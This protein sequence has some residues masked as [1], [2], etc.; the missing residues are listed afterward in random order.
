M[1]V[2]NKGRESHRRQDVFLQFQQNRR[3]RSLPFLK[4]VPVQSCTMPEILFRDGYRKFE[5]QAPPAF[6]VGRHEACS[7]VR[8][9][10]G[11]FYREVFLSAGGKGKSPVMKWRL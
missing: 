6:G 11:I 5:P 10:A 9:S 2:K 1:L 3:K 7:M 4:P 8:A